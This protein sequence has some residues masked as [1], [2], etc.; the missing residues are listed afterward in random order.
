MTV[1]KFVHRE[2]GCRESVYG[3]LPTTSVV[4]IL[5]ALAL[6][7]EDVFYDLGAGRGYLHICIRVCTLVLLFECCEF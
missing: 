6:T 2:N 3:E 7:K 4:H 5:N 1:H